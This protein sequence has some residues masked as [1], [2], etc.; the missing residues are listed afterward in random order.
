MRSLH[1]LCVQYCEATQLMSDS[2]EC[3]AE[4]DTAEQ[5]FTDFT[6]Y[7]PKGHLLA[8]QRP[9]LLARGMQVPGPV[10]EQ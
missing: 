9:P 8:E 3:P 6:Q 7:S 2:Q 5:V 1:L 10:P 4:A